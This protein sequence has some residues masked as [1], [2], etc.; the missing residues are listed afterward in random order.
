MAER[1]E[2]IMTEKK[3]E[4][5]VEEVKDK[6]KKDLEKSIFHFIVFR[7]VT[8]LKHKI[9]RKVPIILTKISGDLNFFKRLIN[10]LSYN[11]KLIPLKNP[12]I[13]KK[14]RISY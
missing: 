5:K 3:I 6:V 12:K 9:S 7:S 10:N 2:N 11:F 4:D 8:A 1:F 13:L 14:L